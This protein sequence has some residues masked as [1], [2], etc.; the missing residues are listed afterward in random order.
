MIPQ[1]KKFVFDTGKNDIAGEMHKISAKD[2]KEADEFLIE[3][4]LS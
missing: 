2:F 4:L 1:Y 3:H